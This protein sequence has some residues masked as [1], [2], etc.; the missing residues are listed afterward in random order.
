[1]NI[2]LSFSCSPLFVLSSLFLSS[3]LF[4]TRF[5]KFSGDWD[6]AEFAELN[7]HSSG[8]EVSGKPILKQAQKETEVIGGRWIIWELLN[9]LGDLIQSLA[10]KISIHLKPRRYSGKMAS[11]CFVSFIPSE[12]FIVCLCQ[13]LLG[14][15]SKPVKIY[16]PCI[17]VPNCIYLWASQSQTG[18]SCK[19]NSPE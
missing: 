11:T 7:W 16:C 2:G 13:R 15:K 10:H 18:Q 5:F 8:D 17:S 12:T 4:G 14:P 1:M 6:Y 9:T 19:S 3:F